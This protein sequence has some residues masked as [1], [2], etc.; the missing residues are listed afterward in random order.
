[1]GRNYR[2]IIAWQLADKFV[3]DIY[4]VTKNFPSE[5]KFGIVSQIRRA[6]ISVPANI[7]EGANR[8]TKKD[9]LH[10]LYIAKGSL[11]ETDYFL[12]LSKKLG[13]IAAD[14]YKNLKNPCDEVMRTLQGLISAVS[15]EV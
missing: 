2:K 12:H 10:F 14:S 15:Q 5:E 7:V 9:Y 3:I 1:M 4:Q 13:Y 6:A 8:R 11:A